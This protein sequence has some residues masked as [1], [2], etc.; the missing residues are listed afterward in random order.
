MNALTR[1]RLLNLGLLILVGGLVAL[2][3]FEPGRDQPAIIL[4][5][6]KTL[7]SQIEH[8]EAWRPDQEKLEFVRREGRWW[9]TAPGSG[10]ANPILLNQLLQ[11]VA[12]PCPLQYP[13]A[14]LDLKALQLDPPPL[15]LRLDDQEIYFGVT[16]P[17]D[18]LRYLQVGPIVHLCPDRLYRLLSSAAASFLAPPIDFPEARKPGSK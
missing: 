13:I 1:R 12:T 6:L 7:P 8:I 10:L 9:M 17:T 18:G 14:G 5:V 2:V 15:R 16:T 11:E 3:W 4:P